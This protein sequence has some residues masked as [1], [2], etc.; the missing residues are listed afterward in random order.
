MKTLRIEGVQR[1]PVGRH[2]KTRERARLVGEILRAYLR[3]RRELRQAPIETVVERLRST[4]VLERGDGGEALVE[5]R[6]LGFAVVRT[7]TFLPGDTRCLRR[8][9]V[10]MQLLARRGIPPSW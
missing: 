7:L 4:T 5:A 1:L 3:A 2:L 6:R 9:L 8:S 10:L